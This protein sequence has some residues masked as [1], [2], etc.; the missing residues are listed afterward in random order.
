MATVTVANISNNAITT[1][2]SATFQNQ[3]SIYRFSFKVG[4]S[5]PF[6]PEDF[7]I[8]ASGNTIVQRF[9]YDNSAWTAVLG[10]SLSVKY[11]DNTDKPTDHFYYVSLRN[12]K[13]DGETYNFTLH[14]SNSALYMGSR[15]IPNAEHDLNGRFFSAQ[16][17]TVTQSRFAPITTGS[18]I[19]NSSDVL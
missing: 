4:D 7:T 3:Q 18:G 1:K 16:D 5:T 19:S 17:I 6:D 12:E 14:D 15:T 8:S 11:P 13:T 2:G 9:T 10:K